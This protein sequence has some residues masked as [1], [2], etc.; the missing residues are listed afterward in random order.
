MSVSFYARGALF[1]CLAALGTSCQVYRSQFDCAPSYGMPCASV[2]EIESRIIETDDGPD[3]FLR[4]HFPKHD[5]RE[6]PFIDS[7]M[8]RLWISP[9]KDPS[10]TIIEG[11][12]VYFSEGNDQC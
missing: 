1:S 11:H 2:S 3:L 6:E 4:S 12:Y 7:S 10:G 8:R 9:S 5:L